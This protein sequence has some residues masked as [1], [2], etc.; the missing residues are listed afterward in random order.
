MPRHR[1]T[2]AGPSSDPV[3]PAA[4]P[5]AAAHPARRGAPDSAVDTAGTLVVD[6]ARAAL[7][8]LPEAWR[9]TLGDLRAAHDTA[10]HT[11][12]AGPEHIRS[13]SARASSSALAERHDPR[14]RQLAAT[15]L[16][17]S[18]RHELALRI[19]TTSPHRVIVD[20]G[21]DY[22][23]GRLGDRARQRAAAHIEPCA[24]CT[25]LLPLFASSDA[26][27]DA[28]NAWVPD[29]R[30]RTPPVPYFRTGTSARPIGAGVATAVVAAATAG[31][32]G[33][34]SAVAAQ[35]TAGSPLTAIS[36]LI[37][38][39]AASLRRSRSAFTRGTTIAATATVCIVSLGI[40]TSIALSAAQ[41]RV[42]FPMV[43]AAGQAAQAASA[44]PRPAVPAEPRAEVFTKPSTPP[45]VPAEPGREQEPTQPVE[46]AP[47]IDGGG[48][49]PR[50][51]TR[52]PVLRRD[53][54]VHRPVLPAGGGSTGDGAPVAGATDR[55][56]ADGASGHGTPP[57]APTAPTSTP[58]TPSPSTPSTAGEVTPPPTS[59]VDPAAPTTT[60]ASAGTAANA[61]GS[62]ATNAGAS[63]STG[64]AGSADSG[65]SAGSTGSTPT[66][67]AGGNGSSAGNGTAGGSGSGS[68]QATGPTSGTTPSPNGPAAHNSGS[69]TA[70][71]GTAAGESQAPAA[72]PVLPVRPDPTPQANVAAPVAP[73]VPAAS[74]SVSGTAGPTLTA[75]GSVLF[76][77][78][79]RPEPA[80]PMQ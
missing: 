39:L 57:T 43:L 29:R 30:H 65:G 42:A 3:G 56:A 77:A 73:P 51:P 27:V 15:G 49:T 2:F 34:S 52:A 74:P 5:S 10:G 21:D 22:Q 64:S 35:I 7:D 67:S 79:I 14:L 55:A 45:G 46:A 23:A 32:V 37:D 76:D 44:S 25:Q 1:T 47:P 71:S 75:G 53:A 19:D 38:G 16:D 40:G 72:A 17:A 68:G 54:P 61:A 70:D 33:V 12:H 8:T 78:S 69:T 18:W 63:A 4:T 62:S 6:S 60:G 13:R 48:E 80:P 28:A 11:R 36:A 24:L 26:I 31:P 59:P 20:R 58:T 9:R 41:S 66:A 50:T